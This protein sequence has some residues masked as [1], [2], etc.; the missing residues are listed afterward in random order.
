MRSFLI[1]ISAVAVTLSAPATSATPSNSEQVWAT[2]ERRNQSWV[3]GK[4]DEYLA[5][6]HPD[7][8]RWHLNQ[9]RLDTKADVGAFWDR[10]H[11]NETSYS[12]RVIPEKLQFLAGGKVAIAHYTVEEVVRIEPSDARQPQQA[13]RQARR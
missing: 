12:I 11:R 5:I 7:Y 9:P 3:E 1:S 13:L 10:L 2:V 4:R 8:L 6:H